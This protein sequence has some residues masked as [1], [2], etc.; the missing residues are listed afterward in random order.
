MKKILIASTA[1]VLAAGTASA[2]VTLAGGGY[3]GIKHDA[4][5]AAPTNKTQ[6]IDRLQIDITGSKTT[7]SG[8]TFHGHFRIRSNAYQASGTTNVNAGQVGI[9]AGGLDVSVG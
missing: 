3:F 8:L 9:T 2:D 5:K 6:L 7:D 4:S 1:L